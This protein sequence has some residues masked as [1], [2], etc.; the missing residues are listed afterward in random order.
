MDCGLFHYLLSGAQTKLEC[1]II[2]AN[3][4]EKNWIRSTS[5]LIL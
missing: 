1:V 2:D 4:K 3:W 5:M